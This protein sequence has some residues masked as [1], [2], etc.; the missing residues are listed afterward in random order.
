MTTWNSA[1][2]HLEGLEDSVVFRG[3]TEITNRMVTIRLSSSIANSGKDF[4]VQLTPIIRRN[5][6]PRSY[7]KV[8]AATNVEINKYTG[9]LE[10]D[11]FGDVG[12]FDWM[13]IGKKNV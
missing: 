7:T 10:F 3:R 5:Q 12:F 6:T 1:F 13:L 9:E 11:V 8:Y 2:T 4:T